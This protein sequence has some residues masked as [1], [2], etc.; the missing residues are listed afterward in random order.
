MGNQGL[1]GKRS[2]GFP[3]G[4]A[5]GQRKCYFSKV[6]LILFLCQ[7]EKLKEIL[8]A[9]VASMFIIIV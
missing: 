4:Q 2:E 8:S 3:G 1:S 9:N 6:V 7:Q 5:L